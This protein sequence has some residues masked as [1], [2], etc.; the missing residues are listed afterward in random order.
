M[1]TIVAHSTDLYE[2]CIFN[3]LSNALKYTAAGRITVQVRYNETRVHVSIMDTGCGIEEKELSLI[4]DRC[5]PKESGV[6][7]NPE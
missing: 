7:L 6:V 2:K 5:V 4:F 3:L 1:F